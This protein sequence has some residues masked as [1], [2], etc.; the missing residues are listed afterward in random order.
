MLILAIDT[1]AAACSVAL[2]HDGIVLQSRQEM[3]PRGQDAR[4]LPLI[5]EIL[6]AA[7]LDFAALDRIAVMRGPGSF[8]GV[9]IGLATA[10]GLGLAL[11]KPVIGV[12]RF[13]IYHHALHP[14]HNLLVVIDSKRDELFCRYFPAVGIATEPFRATAAMLKAY[15]RPDVIVG[16]DGIAQR[17]WDHAVVLALPEPEVNLAAVLAA[18][19]NPDDPAWQPVPLYLRPPDVSCGPTPATEEAALETAHAETVL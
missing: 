14:A 18:T 16:G 10:R 3:M 6:A 2:W 13:L 15:D 9:R 5:Q 12:N 1:S 11:D 17:L 8:T 19:A 4:L 7:Q